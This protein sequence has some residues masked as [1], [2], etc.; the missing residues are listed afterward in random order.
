[1]TPLSASSPTSTAARRAVV[2]V[3]IFISARS[4]PPL[5]PTM[6]A[7][8]AARAA[9]G[10]SAE[11]HPADRPDHHSADLLAPVNGRLPELLG[12]DVHGG[13]R[14]RPGL[15]GLH[16]RT[17]CMVVDLWIQRADG[18]VALGD[19]RP[20]ALRL[21]PRYER[22]IGLDLLGAA[23]MVRPLWC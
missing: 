22:R 2:A 3:A 15:G 14:A 23:L 7:L 6:W 12:R 8:I 18:L 10:A 11:A 9:S 19:D 20:R 13:E 4:L 21:L 17:T 16:D 5:A 1:V